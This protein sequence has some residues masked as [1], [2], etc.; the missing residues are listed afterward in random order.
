MVSETTFEQ[1]SSSSTFLSSMASILPLLFISA[2]LFTVSIPIGFILNKIM[3]R[4]YNK[5]F[6]QNMKKHNL[7][8]ENT[9]VLENTKK[10]NSL[11]RNNNVLENTKKHNL[12]GK[13]TNVLENTKHLFGRNTNVLEKHHLFGR[14][15]V[16][17]KEKQEQLTTKHQGQQQREQHCLDKHKKSI[18]SLEEWI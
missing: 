11:G 8:G 6:E 13:N 18:G 12:F 5:R 14:D 7:L 10:Y 3:R 4:V 1:I 15:N 2:L 9:N 17:E 16:L